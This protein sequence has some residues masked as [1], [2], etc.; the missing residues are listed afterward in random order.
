MYFSRFFT[1]NTYFTLT[2]S[3]RDKMS[4]ANAAFTDFEY[5]NTFAAVEVQ[6]TVNTPSS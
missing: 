5:K 1:I 3:R 4:N 6:C 2:H